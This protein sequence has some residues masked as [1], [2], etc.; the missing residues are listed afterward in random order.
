MRRNRISNVVA[1][2]MMRRRVS[3]ED[4]GLLRDLTLPG[5]CV[6]RE[7][8]ADLI[9]IERHVAVRDRNWEAFFVDTIAAHF[10]WE[11]RPSGVVAESDAR[12]LVDRMGLDSSGATPNTAALAARWKVEGVA[13]PQFLLRCIE[14]KP[15]K[16]A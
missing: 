2:I 5:G 6:T 8:A 3:G 1:R 16:A 9:R 12:W 10:A 7:E 11:T 15:T 13:L 4:V 14:A